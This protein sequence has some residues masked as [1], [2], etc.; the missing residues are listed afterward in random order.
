MVFL[1]VISILM[2][3]LYMNISAIIESAIVSKLEA[4]GASEVVIGVMDVNEEATAID[5]IAFFIHDESR[6]YHFSIHE[7]TVSYE[8]RELLSGRIHS[9]SVKDIKVN[10]K[11]LSIV[12]PRDVGSKNNEYQNIS[13]LGF[14]E[15]PPL[16]R[17]DIE[18][19][20]VLAERKTG[21]QQTIVLN[22]DAVI[23]QGAAQARVEIS[24]G[25]YTK[26]ELNLDI[27]AAGKAMLTVAAS[28]KA[29]DL[30][31]Y[32]RMVANK[33]SLDSQRL[34]TDISINIDLGIVQEV[35]RAWGFEPLQGTVQGRLTAQGPVNIPFE[36][37]SDSDA[38]PWWDANG[39]AT[40]QSS[41]IETIGQDIELKL[42]FK[43]SMDNELIQWQFA[44]TANLSLVPDVRFLADGEIKEAMR[45][46]STQ[47]MMVTLPQAVNVSFRKIE[48]AYDSSTLMLDEPVKLVYGDD[49][50]KLSFEAL[51][52]KLQL[53]MHKQPILSFDAGYSFALNNTSLPVKNIDVKGNT[54]VQLE[55]DTLK[56][57]LQP[58]T[59][60]VMSDIV[61]DALKVQAITSKIEKQANCKY[62]VKGGQWQ[63]GTTRLDVNVSSVQ[64]KSAGLKRMLLGVK[65]D[66]AHGDKQSWKTKL[67]A[68]SADWLITINE[69]GEQRQVKLDSIE[70][71]ISAANDEIIASFNIGAAGDAVKLDVAASHSLTSNKG[72]ASYRLKPVD[73]SNNGSDI[74]AIYDG[75]PHKLVITGG[76]VQAKG[77]I[78]W[79]HS[80][81]DA[82]VDAIQHE[83]RVSINDIRGVFDDV[84]FSGM[85][86]ELSIEGV[87]SFVLKTK[88]LLKIATLDP[89]IPVNDVSLTASTSIEAGNKPVISIADLSMSLLGGDVEGKSIEIDL[90]REENPF[91]VEISNID[92]EA[93]LKLEQKQ[94]LYGTGVIDGTLPLVLTRSGLFMRNG[95]IGAR[96][97]GGKLRYTADE[98]VKAMA[99]SNKGVELLVKAMEDFNYN[100]LNAQLNYQPD[101]RLK[102]KVELKGHN[103]ELEDGRPVHLNVDVED[104]ILALMRSL[105]LAGDIS[106][107]IGDKV[108]Q[109]NKAR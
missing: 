59:S 52:E 24:L 61:K 62:T 37:D 40:V 35:I 73:M 28:D 96:Q 107:K 42:P 36:H 78:S 76:E 90:N 44:N 55:N 54:R 94:G 25:K 16:N 39:E 11:E 92:V 43:L 9:V 33:I 80:A 87:E 14:L 91:T 10:I 58:G 106:E 13:L 68:T 30:S 65:I 48:G 79:Q 22:G 69:N 89:G 95:K 109:R 98:R 6:R 27:N 75:W 100:T 34:G 88:P 103:P 71:E 101:G 74:S 60:L 46:Q 53:S 70:T 41:E 12:K 47:R 72:H 7:L 51:L 108:Q 32:I 84:P 38:A 45:E 64:R 26:Q 56:I 15:N 2:L 18:N 23:R 81:K 57:D 49:K 21:K 83:G 50:A 104:N 63:C 86:S 20:E 4:I 31:P 1:V 97:P 8:P 77:D 93:L 19:I 29:N 66:E 82:S 17:F 85:N 105:R 3:I 99:A 67:V 102:M 5:E